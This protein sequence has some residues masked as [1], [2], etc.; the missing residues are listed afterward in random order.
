MERL[1]ILCH[2]MVD[3]LQNVYIFAVPF[4]KK[5]AKSI[6]DSILIWFLRTN[7][8]SKVAAGKLERYQAYQHAYPRVGAAF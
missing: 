1:K 2:L 8:A 4:A 5:Q 7:P 6:I 3:I